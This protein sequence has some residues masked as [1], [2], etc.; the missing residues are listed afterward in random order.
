MH[1]L[2]M[3]FEGGKYCIFDDIYSASSEMQSS[4]GNNILILNYNNY[5]NGSMQ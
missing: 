3:Y 1:Y 5:N 4:P 2:L